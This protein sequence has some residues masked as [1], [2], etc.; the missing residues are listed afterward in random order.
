M[1]SKPESFNEFDNNI[2]FNKGVAKAT[3]KPV[4]SDSVS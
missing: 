3:C 1:G 2:L 4:N